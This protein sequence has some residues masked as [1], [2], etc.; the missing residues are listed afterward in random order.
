MLYSFIKKKLKH[1]LKFTT[2]FFRQVNNFRK[3]GFG[4]AGNNNITVKITITSVTAGARYSVRFRSAR[5][6]RKTPL[7]SAITSTIANRVF[8]FFKKLRNATASGH[9]PTFQTA[10]ETETITIYITQTRVRSANNLESAREALLLPYLDR[11]RGARLKRK[12][13]DFLRHQVNERDRFFSVRGR[14]W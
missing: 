12:A 6:N 14:F 13:K 3:N 11:E 2:I 10:V 7:S 1:D 9:Y 4:I 8:F 5:R